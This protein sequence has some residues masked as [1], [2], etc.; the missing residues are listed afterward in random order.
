MILFYFIS[1]V[2]IVM[3]LHSFSSGGTSKF[4]N[5]NFNLNLTLPLPIS[6]T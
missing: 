1:P 3:H 2:T 4:F 5:L 6:L